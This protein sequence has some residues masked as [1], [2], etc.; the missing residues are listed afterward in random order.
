ML[1]LPDSNLVFLHIPRTGGTFIKGAIRQLGIRFEV[2]EKSHLPWLEAQEIKPEADFFTF[3]R[4][5]ATWLQ[6]YWGHRMTIGWG[7]DLTIAHE[8]Q[9]DNFN[10]FTE[11]VE[12]DYPGFI[13]ELYTPYLKEGMPIQVGYFENLTEDLHRILESAGEQSDLELIESIRPINVTPENLKVQ[14]EYKPEVY[15]LVCDREK[16]IMERLGY[17]QNN[18]RSFPGLSDLE[19]RIR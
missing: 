2:I 8:Y 14:V 7:G 15:S 16:K 6:S 4:H 12:T 11:K 19:R 18:I 10:R 13:E 5:P 9:D 17:E 3:V 1:Y